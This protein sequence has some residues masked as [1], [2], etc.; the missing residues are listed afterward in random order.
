MRGSLGRAG[1]RIMAGRTAILLLGMHRSGTSAATRLFNMLGADLPT[2]LM[3]PQSDNPAG[4][5]ESSDIASLHDKLFL[6]LRTTWHDPLPVNP[7]W[8]SSNLAKCFEDQLLEL[9]WRDF[10]KS[11]LFIIKDPRICKLVPLWKNTLRRFDT[12]PRF[13][14]LLRN[15]LEVAKSLQRRNGFT[16]DKGL[17]L[18]LVHTLLSERGTRGDVR[19]IISYEELL[20]DWK[21]VVESASENLS[22]QFPRQAAEI[23]EEVDSFLQGRNNRGE[24]DNRDMSTLDG[25]G[26]WL[27]PMYR[28]LLACAGREARSPDHRVLDDVFGQIAGQME[29][30]R[31]ILEEQGTYIS[32]VE[33]R[34]GRLLESLDRVRMDF[35]VVRSELDRERREASETITAYKTELERERQYTR[36]ISAGYE[37]ELQRERQ[38]GADV[39]R[40]YEDELARQKAGIAQLEKEVTHNKARWQ[41]MER[42]YSWRVTA[43]IR[44]MKLRAWHAR[45]A[46]LGLVKSR[47]GKGSEAEEPP[48]D[49]PP[50]PSPELDSFLEE[51]FPGEPKLGVIQ[52]FVEFGLP[53]HG[54]ARAL[55]APMANDIERW[56]GAIQSLD[57]DS[58][59]PETPDVSIVISVHDNIRYTLSSIHSILRQPSRYSYEIVLGDDCSND[60]TKEVFQNGFNKIRYIR[61]ESALGF[62]GNCNRAA[63]T[64]RGRY[65][66]VL[67]NKTVALP[68]WLDE[69]VD[70]LE[71]SPGIGLAGSKLLS[72][73]GHLRE[74]G[75]II[76]RDGSAWAYGRGDDAHRPEYSY[77]RDV[78]Y[79]SGS[80]IALRKELWEHLGGF[81]RQYDF[82][83][84]DAD[85][86]F[87]VREAGF[88]SVVQPLSMLIHFEDITRGTDVAGAAKSHQIENLKKFLARW[89]GSLTRHRPNGKSLDLEKERSVNRRA[90]LIDH[91]TP[92][93]DKDAGSVTA[94]AT[95]R[96]LQETGYKVT[97][98]P[99]TNYAFVGDDSRRLQRLG[100]E[101][102]YGPYCS[103]LDN[104]LSASG[105]H[106]DVVFI[107]RI[108]Q[109]ANY[110]ERVR[111]LCPQ[112]RIIFHTIDLHFLREIREAE[113][114]SSGEKLAQAIQQ[115]ERELE[116]MSAANLT[117]VHSEFE[118]QT[119]KEIL[120]SLETYVFPLILDVVGRK[121]GFAARRDVA[122]LGGYRHPPNVDAVLYF[123]RQIWTHI[124][125][126][127]PDIR[128][129]VVG[130]YPPG[131]IIDLDGL[132][133]VKVLGYV[134]DLEGLLEEVRLTV[135]PL[136]YG[137]GIKG[138]I[139]TSLSHGVPC[140]GT[141][142]AAEG[143]G[144]TEGSDIMVS[145]DPE[146]FAN[147]VLTTYGDEQLWK[148]LSD[149]G[150]KFVEEH[151][152][153]RRALERIQEVLELV[154]ADVDS[155][156]SAPEA[157]T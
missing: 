45:R 60:A 98:L 100:I 37:A 147:T 103:S 10:E 137:A 95:M 76:W 64:A 69:L 89:D 75:G 110:L 4:F 5:W 148:R 22:I 59:K 1:S 40:A 86:A 8:F 81:D 12:E 67:G 142:I 155:R 38:S 17:F 113:L 146:E 20:R 62:I 25:F 91:I 156:P 108:N 32:E 129:L 77:M 30:L 28:E 48:P 87:R 141:T 135:A 50:G 71:T 55:K 115:R 57:T 151:Y 97:F 6:S 105:R 79:C 96:A 157:E 29:K 63:A 143:M 14:L 65:L 117:I 21:A 2:N 134:N 68:R 116:L 35:E 42:S 122:F 149:N 101:V 54:D 39:A 83:Y 88:R 84:C 3:E 80:S 85:L 121:N 33:E 49:P 19:S 123:V 136:R 112:T 56:L 31:P 99:A 118:Q 111:E 7:D 41:A 107:F 102:L 44:F 128:F 34:C 109:A 26:K 78:D 152:S 53:F 145:D 74:A 36:E 46:A 66:V 126:E 90:L 150:M 153:F 124:H 52:H 47:F 119:L 73:D 11:H 154:G 133:N 132:E 70:T 138:K 82:A 43:P 18:W 140:V 139:G 131:E 23:E 72:P 125:R 13:V 104:Y 130:S 27:V 114:E 92:E 144:L 127:N 9:L 106:L 94:L 51:E 61:N 24:F 16:L 58:H 15:P 120:P 93:P